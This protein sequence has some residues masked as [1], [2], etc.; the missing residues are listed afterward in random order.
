AYELEW[1]YRVSAIR[2]GLI[3]AAYG[4]PSGDLDRTIVRGRNPR[5]AAEAFNH[6]QWSLGRRLFDRRGDRIIERLAEDVESAEFN[7]AAGEPVVKPKGGMQARA[8]D[9]QEDDQHPFAAGN[10][11]ARQW[12]VGRCPK[13]NFRQAQNAPEN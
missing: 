7:S 2:T 12:P 10:A 5:V 1:R 3:H 6:D 4:L 8:E 11:V 13:Q 9:A